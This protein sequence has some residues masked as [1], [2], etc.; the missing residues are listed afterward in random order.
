MFVC[1]LCV[2][3]GVL[4]CGVRVRDFRRFFAEGWVI[5]LV[6]KRLPSTFSFCCAPECEIISA[7]LCEIMNVCSSWRVCFCGYMLVHKIQHVSLCLCS[8]L[9]MFVLVH[10][11]AVQV[12]DRVTQERI[13]VCKERSAVTCFKGS[14]TSK[15]ISE[16]MWNQ[17]ARAHTPQHTGLSALLGC[18]GSGLVRC[19]HARSRATVTLG[20][21]QK[22]I[23]G[24][25]VC[26]CVCVCAECVC[27]ASTG[28]CVPA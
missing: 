20:S 15:D 6:G 23:S 14:G 1:C 18:G 10:G 7:L 27:C 19:A 28:C 3:V 11:I 9:C 4:W 25:I 13:P 2:G 22:Q 17:N 26:V 21:G 8:S 5:R 12:L 24:S 16:S